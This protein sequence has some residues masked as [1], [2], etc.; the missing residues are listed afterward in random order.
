MSEL[1]HLKQL[2]IWN[3]SSYNVELNNQRFEFTQVF[4][5]T[6]QAFYNVVRF[7]SAYQSVI[8][9]QQHIDCRLLN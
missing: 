6:Q 4:F 8:S 3:K 9:K 5:L 2:T 1:K 7:K